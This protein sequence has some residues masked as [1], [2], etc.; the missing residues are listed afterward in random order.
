MVCAEH[1]NLPRSVVKGYREARRK[2]KLEAL[3]V[4]RAWASRVPRRAGGPRLAHAKPR[5]TAA[6]ANRRRVQGLYLGTLKSL[7]GDAR[8]RVQATAREKG[9]GEALK[10]ARSLK[11]AGSA[12]A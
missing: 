4:G 5:V 6:V 2:A 8:A 1:K 9:V 12:A 10:L 11:S 7:T 3:R